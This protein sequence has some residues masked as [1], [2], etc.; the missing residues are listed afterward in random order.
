MSANVDSMFS[1]REMPWHREGVIL[2][3]YPGSWAEARIQAGLDWDPI[4][5][6]IYEL[7]GMDELG[8]PVY[9]GIYGWKRIANSK[10]METLSVRPEGYT[11]IDHGEMGEIIES[12]L[13]QPN[14]QY[15][16]AGSLNNGKAVW[17]LVK[18]DEPF[19]L[20]GD[21]SA[22]IPYM[23]I[24]N[25]HDGTA[26]CTLRATAVRIVCANTFRAAEMEGDRTGATYT[27]RHTRNWREHLDRAREA[28]TG[29]RKEI[30]DYK[31]LATNLLGMPITEGQRE[32]FVVNFI[33]APPEGLITERVMNNIETARGQ[34][35][36]LFNSITNE[37]VKDTAYGLVQASVEYLDHVR[38]ANSW[39]TKLGRSLMRP[40]PLKQ[41]ALALATSIAKN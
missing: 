10:T 33:P 3:E 18:L 39:E 40:E 34:L 5:M 36:G 20:P 17:C 22:V 13:E 9:K 31:V 28:V 30:E 38:R 21:D 35:R 15:E 8:Q 2:N 16:T 23:A 27:F 29:T 32:L 26:G 25:R 11:I 41:R 24:T 12:V 1:V 37:Q 14:V 7:D 19:T 6:E 4:P